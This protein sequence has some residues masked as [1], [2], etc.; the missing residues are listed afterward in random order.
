MGTLADTIEDYLLRMLTGR[1]TLEVR[2]RELALH[3]RCAPS[4]INYVLGT[5]FTV[6][7]GY[8][9]ESKRG[10]GGFIRIT[11]LGD[12]NYAIIGERV[13]PAGFPELLSKMEKDGI[14][15]RGESLLI[16]ETLGRALAQP[17]FD[18]DMARA[19]MLRAVL[20]LLRGRAR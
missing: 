16:Q 2:R 8:L 3:F 12:G 19:S 6:T 7:R 1:E 5:R 14:I 4:Q 13:D 17:G 20:A 11:R 9:V 15:S 10:G 18:P